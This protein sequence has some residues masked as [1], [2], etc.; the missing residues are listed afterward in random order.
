[1]WYT[2]TRKFQFKLDSY[3][4]LLNKGIKPGKSRT[5]QDLPDFSRIA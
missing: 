3:T 5:K 4:V 1:M 2:A